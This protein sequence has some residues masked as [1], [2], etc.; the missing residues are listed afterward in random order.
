MTRIPPSPHRIR[1]LV[2][3]GGG[4]A[5]W[6]A[7]AALARH[8]HGSDLAIT[9]VESS[10]IGTIGVGEATIPTF[11]RFY[12]KLGIS[13]RAVMR[14][15]DATVKMGIR[16]DDWKRVG[17]GFIHPFGLYGQNWG[18]IAFHHLW[19]ARR[20]A[21]DPTPISEYSL[22][23]KLAETGRIAMPQPNPP[24]PLEVFDWAL[25]LDAT[26]FAQFLRQYAE[27]S[28]VRRIDAKVVGVETAGEHVSAVR[29][30]GDRRVEGDFF[31]DCTG[32]RSLL[33]GEALGVGFEEWGHWLPCDAAVAVQSENALAEP[34]AYTR[35]QA[36][37]AGWQWRIPLRHRAG[38]GLVYASAQMS[39]DEA[40]ASLLSDLPGKPLTDP[41]RIPFRPGRRA[42]AWKG[43]VVALGLAAGFL[44]PL[45]STSI[46]LIE[47]AIE[48]LK[49]LFPDRNLAPALSAE[50][51]DAT[52]RE[53][54]RVRDFIILHYKLT[55]RDDTAFWRDCA[56]ME[57]PDTLRRKLELWDARGEFIRYRWEMFHPASWL[58]IYTGFDRSPDA[59]NPAVVTVDPQQLDSAMQRMRAAIADTL[60]RAPTHSQFLATIEP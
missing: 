11:R 39:E 18:D 17:E 49:E 36:K 60:R 35:S 50:F 15:T 3:V 25:H 33:L 1:S 4:T 7:A 24:A 56:A 21:G 40:T 46:A 44:E 31:I 54:E 26:R 13:D 45:E 28:G 5:G 53:M 30:E 14:A 9:L 10:E 16:F 8:F 29:L 27:A 55:R 20:A 57:V 38:N 6:M 22:G 43:N 42:Q 2:I 23:V 12:A 32:F 19:Y 58:A 34:P 47:T 51:N 41:R 59:L 48:R 52:A 37:A